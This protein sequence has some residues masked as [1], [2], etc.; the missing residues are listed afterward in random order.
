MDLSEKIKTKAKEIGFSKVGITGTEPISAEFQRRYAEWLSKGYNARMLYL[1]RG[2]E[3]RLEPSR[4]LEGAKSIISLAVSY[5]P[6]WIERVEDKNTSRISRYALGYDYHKVISDKLRLLL[7]FIINEIKGEVKGVIYCDAGPVM[8]KVIAERA[9]L[10]WVGKN[11]LLITREFGSWVFLGEIILD[12]EIKEDNPG[13]NL[14]SD[15]NLCI[16]SCPTGAIIAPGIINASRCLSYFTTENRGEIPVE[17]RDALGN[18][19]FGCD[20]CQEICPFNKNVP[21][22][23]EPLFKPKEELVSISLERLFRLVCEDFNK[24]F[25]NSAIKRVKRGG[26]LQSIIVAMG[27]SENRK[28]LPLLKRAKEEPDPILQEHAEWAIGKIVGSKEKDN[29][30]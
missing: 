24:S 13:E 6:G 5:Y 25:R 8:E 27:N 19:V 29:W 18:R 11:T 9:G 1:E 14:C 20:S 22:T 12:V 3:E 17:L 30:N 15:C 10:G 4:T 23:D 2:I 7:N 28:F 26:L 16:E 21:E